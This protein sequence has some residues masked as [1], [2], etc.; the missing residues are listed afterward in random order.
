MREALPKGYELIINA[1]SQMKI[2]VGEVIGEG[3]SCIAYKGEMQIGVPVPVVLKECFPLNLPIERKSVLDGNED[4][5]LIISDKENEKEWEEKFNFR[6]EKFVKGILHNTKIACLNE[7]NEFFCVGKANNT[8]YSCSLYNKGELLSEYIKKHPMSISEI[9]E[10]M[11]SLCTSVFK[12]HK[13]CCIYLDCKPDNVFVI[14]ENSKPEARVIDFDTIILYDDRNAAKRPHTYSFGWAAPEQMSLSKPVSYKTDIFSIGAIFFWMLTGEKPYQVSVNDVP[15]N[16]LLNKI[17]QGT[18]EWREKAKV[19]ADADQK[20][21]DIIQNIAKKALALE[22]EDRGYQSIG[23][24]LEE[25]IGDLQ[26]LSK[27]TERGITLRAASLPISTNRFKYNSNLTLLRGRE[28]E[29]GFLTDMCNAPSPFCWTGIC[30]AGG[31]G[32]SRLAYDLCLRMIKQYWHVFSPIRYNEYTKSDILPVLKNSRGNILI[33]LDYIKQDKEDIVLLIQHII[34]NIHKYDYKIRLILIERDETD[35]LMDDYEVEKYK[36]T[37]EYNGEFFNGVINLKPLTEESIRNIVVDYI[38]KQSSLAIISEDDLEV[39][40]KTLRAIDHEYCRPL[41]ALFIADAWINN[42]DVLKWDRN[43]A[44]DYLLKREMQ[45]LSSII[46]DPKNYFNALQQ[47]TYFAAVRYLYALA[48]YLGTI[49]LSDYNDIL[50]E[51]YNLSCNDGMLIVILK[52]FG[53][54]DSE[55]NIEGWVPDLIGEYF[56]VDW[57][58]TCYK[59]GGIEFVKDFV[60]RIIDRD[61]SSFVNYSDQI[62]KD[63]SDIVSNLPWIDALQN[64]EF[65]SKYNF[66]R[67]KQFNGRIFLKNISFKGRITSIQIGAFNDC[68]NLEKIIFPASL[69]VIEKYAFSGCKSLVEVVSEDGKAEN[70]SIIKIESFAFQNCISLKTVII[71]DSVQEIGKSAFENCSSL[72]A[73]RMPRKIYKI[74]SSTFA[75]CSSLK[76]VNLVM[77]KK[78]HIGDSCFSGCEQLEE[79]DGINKIVRIDQGAFRNCKNLKSITLSGELNTIEEDVFSGCCSLSSI[80]LSACKI[81]CIPERLFYLCS[82][83]VDISLPSTINEIKDKSFF[84]CKKLPNIKF[85]E[86]IK[87]IGRH[88]FSGCLDFKYL[89]IPKSLKKI[90]SYAFENC[91]GISGISFATCSVEIEDHAFCDC[92]ALLF[93]NIKGIQTGGVVNYCG[94][95]FTSFSASDFDFVQTY[96]KQEE[97]VVPE[98]VSAIGRD[99]FRGQKDEKGLFINYTLKKVVLPTKLK[100]IGDRAFAGCIGLETVEFKNNSFIQLGTDVFSGCISL[101]KI[102]GPNLVIEIYDSTF[103]NC[104]AMESVGI[105][106]KVAKIVK[107]DFKGCLNLKYINIKDHWIPLHIGALAFAGCERLRYPTDPYKME[108]NRIQTRNFVIYGFKF[109]QFSI[110][111]LKFIKDYPDSEELN[112]P[113]TCIDISAVHFSDNKKLRKITIPNSIKKISAEIFRGCISLETVELPTSLRNIPSYAFAECKSLHSICFENYVPNCI[114]EGVNVESAAFYGCKSLTSILLPNTLTSIG[115]YT[116]YGCHSLKDVQIPSSI[117]VIGNYAFTYCTSLAEIN[118]PSS[119]TI[120]GKGVFKGCTSLINVKNMEN[121]KLTVL[122]NNL[123]ESCIHLEMVALSSRIKVIKGHA[124]EDCHTLKIPRNFLPSGLTTLEDAAFQGCYSIERIRIPR[125]ILEIR[126]YTFKQCS[127]LIEVILPDN[128]KYIGQ[129]AFYHCNSLPDE[130]INLPDGLETLGVG[131][132]AYCRSFKIITIPPSVQKLPSDL[133]KGCVSLVEASIPDHI[134]E[135]SA[136]CFKDCTSIKMV[137]FPRDLQV[138]NV[139]AFRNCTSLGPKELKF[140]ASLREVRESAFRYCDSIEKIYISNEITKISSAAFEGCRNLKEVI[141]DHHIEKV[142]NYA[143]L[144]CISL[145]NFPFPLVDRVIG[146]AAFCNCKSLNSPTFSETI[147]IINSAAFRGCSSIEIL[148]LPKS[149]YSVCGASFRE[150]SN[151]K[152][153]I[154][155]ATV[156]CIKKSAFR[157]CIN[158]SDVEIKSSQIYLQARA[159]KGCEKLDYIELPQRSSI[160]A[161]TFENCPAEIVVRE[162]S[163]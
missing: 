26:Y 79:I 66:V 160:K 92:N 73:I 11:I 144:D 4:Y 17:Q 13:A 138:I 65:P 24:E 42:E 10:I 105:S 22:P 149:L 62:Y 153:V 50:N 158:L 2:I 114:P 51:K 21:I 72:S 146:N 103:Q 8:L 37:G 159:F 154:I 94:F 99:V 102:I 74:E 126:D 96:L 28:A 29:I 19:C 63:F 35:I 14:T 9:A 116:F 44:L 39:I 7:T 136:D 141:F 162:D 132:F 151:L 55:N 115:G 117:K 33:C 71:P 58:N 98:T 118:L 43:G 6:K 45:S 123:F 53:I 5:S 23:H 134:V 56:C 104:S 129:S 131:A 133:F 81:N 48:T 124:F 59:L 97:V 140:P 60:N 163:E 27:E 109:K 64:I 41:Y 82:S 68:I 25:M 128:L 88:A 54:L 31:T 20:I 113:K 69:E 52:K 111:E 90:K 84:G 100:K 156:N 150:N 85:N 142:D 16:T 15:D 3:G 95:E 107:N 77:T 1:E 86:G 101:K 152:K 127:S 40:V 122:A 135:I 61:L 110:K 46:K 49:C 12:Y 145:E 108:K 125:N 78:I 76:S 87:T 112:I 32:K 36:Y 83:L 18:F 34:D 80:D 75:G 161:D 106:G 147:S 148:N 67:K 89:T 121:T 119:L 157:D 38:V 143:F 91:T 57:F 47:D 130:G 93:S 120:L 155:P 30:G 70:P 137:N 139:G